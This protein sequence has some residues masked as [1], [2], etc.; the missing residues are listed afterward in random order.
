MKTLAR[1]LLVMAGLF[2]LFA[3][4]AMPGELLTEYGQVT[5]L[6]P[7][8]G[9]MILM[10]APGY[11]EGRNYFSFFSMDRGAWTSVSAFFMIVG[12]M[13]MFF[14]F[15]ALIYQA[16]N[17]FEPGIRYFATS[18]AAGLLL[19]GTAAFSMLLSLILTRSKSDYRRFA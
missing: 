13:S 14:S 6:L 11:P 15:L 17:H 8:L 9:I 7:F 3:S 10:V 1:I 4:N 18:F 5:Y 19:G 2:F 12:V 16:H